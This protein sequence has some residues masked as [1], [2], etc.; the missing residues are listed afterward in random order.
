MR[1]DQG[2]ELRLQRDVGARDCGAASGR[3]KL[4]HGR[5]ELWQRASGGAAS[6]HGGGRAVGELGAQADPFKKADM[7]KMRLAPLGA[8]ADPFEK[9]DTDGRTIQTD[10]KR[11]KSM[12]VYVGQLE[13][14]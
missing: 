6:G 13:L 2:G 10:N 4:R 11:T 8:Q 9:A 1:R 3:G 12:S 7:S 14:L 5:G